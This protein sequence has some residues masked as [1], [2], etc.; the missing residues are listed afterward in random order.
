M[1][2]YAP[3][4]IGMTFKASLSDLL[5]FQWKTGGITADFVLPDDP[6]HDL[7]V[8]FDRPCIVRLL[9]E[10]S[11]STEDDVAPSHGLVSEH[12][13]YRME[14]ASFASAQSSAWKLINAPA[15]HYRFVTGWACM[16]VLS[17]ALP[18]FALIPRT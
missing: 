10:M 9:D 8:T 14:G 2:K 5:D 13:A 17:G 4:Q 12:F 6:A 16:D 1:L 15:V 3:I 11:L 7:R 18:L